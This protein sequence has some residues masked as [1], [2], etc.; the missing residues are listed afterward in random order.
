MNGGAATIDCS[1]ENMGKYEDYCIRRVRGIGEDRKGTE[2]I[3]VLPCS[4]F[5]QAVTSSSH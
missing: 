5:I 3:Q 2:E 4:R 1:T